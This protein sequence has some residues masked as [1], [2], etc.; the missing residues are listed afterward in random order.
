MKGISLNEFLNS[1]TF[2]NTNSV[3]MLFSMFY[4][5]NI[6]LEDTEFTDYFKTN[7]L[8]FLNRDMKKFINYSLAQ[9]TKFGIKGQRYSELDSFYRE[10]EN[11]VLNNEN[12][13][14]KDSIWNE[15]KE[16]IQLKEY[17]YIK[18]TYAPGAI[19]IDGDIE[20]ISILGKMFHS[21]IKCNYLKTKV[22]KLYNSFGNR[23]KTI[24][25]TKTKTD[26]K[27]L[28]HSYRIAK[29][30][31]ELISTGFIKF[32]LTYSNK[33]KEIK[34]ISENNVSNEYVEEIIKDIE[35]MF[36]KIDKLSE[37]SVISKNLDIDFIEKTILYFHLK[38]Y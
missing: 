24:A 18:F 29:E 13:S 35:L 26:F 38:E 2:M 17:S 11:L 37:K 34:Y 23:T 8:K 4:K 15:L 30:T 19:G 22:F 6:I 25:K 33:L 36:S 28:S 1:L 14:L 12:I 9:V 31:M 10:L 3:D 7:Y 16:L 27:A 20:Y 32:P 21:D 5:E